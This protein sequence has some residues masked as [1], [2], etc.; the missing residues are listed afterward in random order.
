MSAERAMALPPIFLV[1]GWL[2]L[3]IELGATGGAKAAA[4]SLAI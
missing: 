2:L 3:R 4:V 1:W